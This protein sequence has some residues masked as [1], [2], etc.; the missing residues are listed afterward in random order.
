MKRIMAAGAVVFATL[1]S[2]QP[3]VEI[4]RLKLDLTETGWER[5][6]AGKA[7]IQL[8]SASGDIPG[9][10][11]L[12]VLRGPGGGIT[13]AMV[14]GATWGWKGRVRTTNNC[15]PVGNI[16]TQDFAG[17]KDG[18]MECASAGGLFL[19]EPLLKSSL[20]RL[21]EAL[22]AQ[23]L[24]PS[25]ASYVARVFMINDRGA[26][27]Q[28]DVLLAPDFMGLPGATPLGK[29]PDKLPP[30]VAAWVDALGAASKD[31][32]YS[33][34]GALKVPPVATMAKAASN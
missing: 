29:V 8:M 22:E 32:L 24:K 30:A 3:P 7:D 23:S 17:G 11:A 21:R 15:Q 14:V 19:T 31:A 2:A 34:S 28:I 12:L 18:V 10:A 1:A 4:G 27:V 16:Y 26:T 13:A 33:F 5:F 25:V 20:P 9:E 6:P